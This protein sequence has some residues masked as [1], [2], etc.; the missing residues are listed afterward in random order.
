MEEV[1]DVQDLAAHHHL[2]GDEEQVH[3]PGEGAEGDGAP[4]EVQ[5]GRR[6]G[7]RGGAEVRFQ[8]QRDAEGYQDEAQGGDGPTR[9]Y[10]V[11]GHKKLVKRTT[12]M[13]NY[14]YICKL[15]PFGTYIHS[16]I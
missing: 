10:V 12:K 15:A 3:H 11:L 8:G 14:A 1:V 6:A 13:H 4:L 16:N 5:D 2:Q 7:D 9:G